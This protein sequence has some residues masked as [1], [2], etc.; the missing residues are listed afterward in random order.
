MI[1]VAGQINFENKKE[2]NS[3]NQTIKGYE[4]NNGDK[5]QKMIK[6]TMFVEIT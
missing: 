6:E 1:T 5:I 4:E 3:S 2:L